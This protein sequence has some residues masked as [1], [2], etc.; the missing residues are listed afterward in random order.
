LTLG[1]ILSRT[2]EFLARKGIDTPRLDAELLLAS[3]LGTDRAALHADPQRVID[4]EAA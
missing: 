2:T 3:V 4:R 1:E